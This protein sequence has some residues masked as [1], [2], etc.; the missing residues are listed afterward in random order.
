MTSSS[1]DLQDLHGGLLLLLLALTLL[2]PQL[3]N[4]PWH[5]LAPISAYILIVVLFAPLRQALRWN[6]VGSLRPAIL[7][8]TG[9]I[10]LL[11]S[12]VLILF[13]VIFQPELIPLAEKLPLGLPLPLV[14]IGAIFSIVNAVLEEIVFRG[15]LFD[16]LIARSELGGR[17]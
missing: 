1:A 14:L 4:W 15:V 16:S 13:N 3:Q 8:A 9:A 12:A 10:V 7:L 6:R 2:L 5:L 17:S 11:S